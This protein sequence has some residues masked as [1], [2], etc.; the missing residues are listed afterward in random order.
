MGRSIQK[1][2]SLYDSLKL[3]YASANR[4]R[5]QTLMFN[6]SLIIYEL[7]EVNLLAEKE[8]YEE[9]DPPKSYECTLYLC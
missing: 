2:A 5:Q 7:F 9:N 3:K 8:K 6:N 1:R 4:P